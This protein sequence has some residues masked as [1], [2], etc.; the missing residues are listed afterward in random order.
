[1]SS[2]ASRSSSSSLGS[3][4]EALAEVMTETMEPPEEACLWLLI[5]ANS[6]RMASS[7]A[8][9]SPLTEPRDF[10]ASFASSLIYENVFEISKIVFII[11][12]KTLKAF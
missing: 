9:A 2:K 10:L 12:K 6:S 11:I 5:M 4:A 1:M 8:L 7:S 3:E